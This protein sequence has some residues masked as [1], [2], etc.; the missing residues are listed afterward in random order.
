MHIA[1]AN[2]P[3]GTSM[4]TIIETERA[5]SICTIQLFMAIFYENDIRFEYG[6]T[7]YHY[8]THFSSEI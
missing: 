3:L 7:S 5:S 4:T 2:V 1:N 8:D 6:F